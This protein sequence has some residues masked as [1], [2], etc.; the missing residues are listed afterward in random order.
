MCLLDFSGANLFYAPLA[1]AVGITGAVPGSVGTT[2]V[3]F[4]LRFLVR[5]GKYRSTEAKCLSVRWDVDGAL[6]EVLLKL[7]DAYRSWL[8]VDFVHADVLQLGWKLFHCYFYFIG[9]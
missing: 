5:V 2:H 1:E 8:C 3:W 4:F 9:I 7:D 6:L